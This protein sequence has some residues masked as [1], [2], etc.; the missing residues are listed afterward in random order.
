M[1][2]AKQNSPIVAPTQWEA[3]VSRYETAR[4]LY[5]RFKRDVLEP[6]EAREKTF[7]EGHALSKDAPDYFERK[8]ALQEA[9]GFQKPRSIEEAAEKLCDEMSDAEDV[10]MST[11]APD[12]PALLFK[13][14]KL[15]SITHGSTDSWSEAY[16]RQTIEDMHLLLK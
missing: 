15:L 9:H 16:A 13:L 14:G 6:A 2:T 4:D 1:N 8:R 12:R 5:E 10:V 11:P 3:A 7:E